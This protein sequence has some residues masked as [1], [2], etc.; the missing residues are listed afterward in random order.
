MLRHALVLAASVAQAAMPLPGHPDPFVPRAATIQ[1]HRCEQDGSKCASLYCPYTVAT[2][3]REGS[4]FHLVLTRS[5][6]GSM[7]LHDSLTKL[8]FLYAEQGSEVRGVSSGAAPGV[9]WSISQYDLP[10]RL[11]LQRLFA[12]KMRIV[13]QCIINDMS[14]I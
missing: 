11:R 8:T 13:F 7:R 10:A 12:S 4:R 6:D 5:A 9:F 1:S 2:N 3:L 14:P